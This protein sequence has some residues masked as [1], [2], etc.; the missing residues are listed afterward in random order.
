MKKILITVAAIFLVFIFWTQTRLVNHPV[1]DNDEGIYLTTLKLIDKG[2]LPYIKTFLSQPPGFLL[3]VYPG[4]TA[5]GKT[6]AGSRLTIAA[7]SVVGLVAIIFIGAELGNIIIGLLS[8]GLLFLIPVYSNQTLVLQSDMVVLAYSLLTVLALIIFTKKASISWLVTSGIFYG[9]AFWTKFDITLIPV[10]LFVLKLA[11]KKSLKTFLTYAAVMFLTW[12]TVTVFLVLP[13]GIKEV[14]NDSFLLRLQSANQSLSFFLLFD[15]LKFNQVLLSVILGS[16][17]LLLIK[18]K[19]LD[20]ISGILPVWSISSL[21]FFFFYRPLFPHHLAILSV[22]FVLLFCFLVNRILENKKTIGYT[23]LLVVTG[24]AVYTRINLI[25][26]TPKNLLDRNRQEAVNFI[27]RNTDVNDVIIS[28]EEI[29]NA[30]SGRLPPPELSDVSYVRIR[31][32]NLDYR[33]VGQIIK[34]VKPKLIVMWNGRL[35]L[36]KGFDGFLEN[37]HEIAGFGKS[38]RIFGLN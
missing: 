37:Y 22:P 36:I 24:L 3:S 21:V 9:L 15:Y 16:A 38:K 35:Q 25:S 6:L 20:R 7:W 13:F 19:S 18:R 1:I 10:I 17:V 32:G 30:L 4:F 2:N 8:A 5:S 29:L 31:S 28:D 27:I 33:L 23:L 26:K 12:L 11:S 34:K 14:I